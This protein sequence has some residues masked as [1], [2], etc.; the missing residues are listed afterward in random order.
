MRRQEELQLEGHCYV[1]VRTNKIHPIAHQRFDFMWYPETGMSLID[2]M[3]YRPYVQSIIT[4]NPWLIAMYP[5][6][7]IRVWDKDEK[8]WVLPD[9][10]TYGASVNGIMMTCLGFSC[11]IPAQALDGGEQLSQKVKEIEDS[12]E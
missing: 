10:Q 2:Q 9:R 5:R 7:K 4:E 3:N 8:R 11:T 12:Y 6:E 1:L